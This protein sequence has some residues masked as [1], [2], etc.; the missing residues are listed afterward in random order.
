MFT[1]EVMTNVLMIKAVHP[2]DS[3]SITNVTIGLVQAHC[4]Y[5]NEEDEVWDHKGC[6]VSLI[7][8]YP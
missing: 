3:G 6:Q 8:L 1:P 7:F 5:W 4:K 2:K